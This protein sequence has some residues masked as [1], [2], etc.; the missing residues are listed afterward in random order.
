MS[1]VLVTIL[2]VFVK[3]E[4]TNETPLK[5]KSVGLKIDTLFEISV[6]VKLSLVKFDLIVSSILLISK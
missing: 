6:I 3:T 1:S 5:V 4:E 2:V